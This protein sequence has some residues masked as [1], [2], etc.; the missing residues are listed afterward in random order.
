MTGVAIIFISMTLFLNLAL[1][2]I[3]EKL[4]FSTVNFLMFFYFYVFL[5]VELRELSK[6]IPLIISTVILMSSFLILGEK[7]EVGRD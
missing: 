5:F 3:K 7:R 4:V 2:R 1:S 6:L